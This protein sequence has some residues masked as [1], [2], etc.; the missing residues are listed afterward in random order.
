MLKTKDPVGFMKPLL[1][2]AKSLQAVSIPDEAMTLTA[3]ETA[4]A[5]RQA[6]F[7]ASVAE[8]VAAALSHLVEADPTPRR[9]LICGSLYLAGRVL[10]AIG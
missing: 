8:D 4:D 3:E 10:S 7:E 6:G 1:G 2:R 9:V 5:A